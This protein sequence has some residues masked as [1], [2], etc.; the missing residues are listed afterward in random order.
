MEASQALDPIDAQIL[1]LL[2]EDARRTVTDIAARVNLTVAPV[3]R[4]IERLERAG[5][6]S[7]YTVVIDHRKVGPS[8][9]AF[10]ELRI[11]GHSDVDDVI[12]LALAMPEVTQ[13]F[14]IAGDP[15]I[16]LRLRVT[17][18][19][20]LQ[21]VVNTLRRSGQVTGTKT[22]MVL[23]SWENTPPAP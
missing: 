6:I 5:V 19:V 10:S 13:A 12:A 11:E 14:S 16:L 8:I 7:G 20:H 9:E 15:D 3:K 17:D 4:R 22:L 1:A 2:R 18:V 21:T 23:G